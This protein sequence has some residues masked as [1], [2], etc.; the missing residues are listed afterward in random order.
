[1]CH[2]NPLWFVFYFTDERLIPNPPTDIEIMEE[3]DMRIRYFGHVILNISWERP[4]SMYQQYY[5]YIALSSVSV[6]T[7]TL[8]NN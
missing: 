8:H 7:S 2:G 3:I 5:I 1:M 4:Q 6:K